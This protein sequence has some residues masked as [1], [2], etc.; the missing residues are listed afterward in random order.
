MPYGAAD[1]SLSTTW[2]IK[3]DI[4]G[5]RIRRVGGPGADSEQAPRRKPDD[6]EVVFLHAMSD[7]WYMDLISS[8]C[9]KGAIDLSPGDGGGLG[10]ACILQSRPILCVAFNE[11][12]AYYIKQHVTARVFNAMM[13]SSSPPWLFEPALVELKGTAQPAAPAASPAPATKATPPGSPAP[14][15][16]HPP[17]SPSASPAAG[18]GGTLEKLK[19]ML[20]ERQAA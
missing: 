19:Q 4:L 13:V 14:S 12:H 3:K 11:T 20:A 10:F 5:D 2:K 15:R 9:Y 17:P 6:E 18:A 8:G 1:T 7:E 16:T